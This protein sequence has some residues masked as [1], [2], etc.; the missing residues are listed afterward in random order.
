[1]TKIHKVIAW[2]EILGGVYGFFMLPF[3]AH[4]NILGLGQLFYIGYTIAFGLSFVAGL[5]L[6]LGRVTGARLSVFVQALQ[7]IHICAWTLELRY[8]S[9]P[10]L[11]F[12]GSGT[13]NVFFSY[14]FVA[15]FWIG[16]PTGEYSV[17]LAINIFSL[18]ALSYLLARPIRRSA[19]T[20]TSELDGPTAVPD[21][22]GNGL[23]GNSADL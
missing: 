7:L 2:C 12:G 8:V 1:M 6:V 17:Y 21:P 20:P 9:G 11:S 10:L 18:A 22:Q 23:E 14:G 15:S 5:L 13:G 4:Q 3:I 16:P 19:L